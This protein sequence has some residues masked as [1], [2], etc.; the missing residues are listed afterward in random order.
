MTDRLI[1]V[2]STDLLACLQTDYLYLQFSSKTGKTVKELQHPF[3][4][5]QDT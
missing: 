4:L 1:I 3:S 5:M 2:R